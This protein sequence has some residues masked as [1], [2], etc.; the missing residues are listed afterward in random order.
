MLYEVITSRSVFFFFS[1]MN[2]VKIYISIDLKYYLSA[3]DFKYF[4]YQDCFISSKF[5]KYDHIILAVDLQIVTFGWLVYLMFVFR[6]QTL[7]VFLRSNCGVG[8]RIT[9]YNV[10]YTKLLRKDDWY[11]VWCKYRNRDY[12]RIRDCFIAPVI[13]DKNGLMHDY[14]RGLEGH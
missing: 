4:S 7:A 11:H 8:N 5:N 10:C 13:Y 9:S 1:L 12:D 14:L 3:D 6:L 2:S